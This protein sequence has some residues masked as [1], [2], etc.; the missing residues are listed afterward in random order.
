MVILTVVPPEYTGG[1]PIIGY[2]VEY[3]SR[4]QDF[5][6]GKSVIEPCVIIIVII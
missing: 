3:E 6:L 4:I 1:M 5:Q 2:R